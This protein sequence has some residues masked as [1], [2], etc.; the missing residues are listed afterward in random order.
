MNN[1]YIVLTDTGSLFTRLIKRF[2]K[3]PYN[4][5]SIA[6]D[7]SL[8]SLFSFGR[9]HP[10]NPFWGGFVRESISGG[11]FKRF[12]NTT[13]MVLRIGV[14]DKEYES[15]TQNIA[16][17]E[18]HKNEYTYNLTGLVAT[19]FDKYVPRKHAYFCSEF[20]AG[21]LYE[22]DITLWDTP[23]HK[24]KPYDFGEDDRFQVL[25]EGRLTDYTQFYE[26]YRTVKT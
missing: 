23:P 17:F 6:F 14:E 10:Y 8:E 13:C 3:H 9:K 11:T 24:V 22:S 19:Y 12:K 4:H 15:L 7:E 20:V 1:V 18:A 25:F 2:T 21:V 16:F 26:S 5:V